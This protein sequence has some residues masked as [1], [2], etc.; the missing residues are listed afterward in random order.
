MAN[1]YINE[2]YKI[3]FKNVVSE[4]YIGK[5]IIGVIENKLKEEF[6]KEN[7]TKIHSLKILTPYL[8]IETI[9]K[10]KYLDE[11]S[12][13]QI[14]TNKGNEK[15]Q[16]LDKIKNN[17]KNI[18]LH[19]FKYNPTTNDFKDKNN[20]L[21]LHAK[22]Y[23]VNEKYLFISSANFT[24]NGTT[25]NFET[26]IFIKPHNYYNYKKKDEDGNPDYEYNNNKLIKN[27]SRKFDEITKDENIIK[28]KETLFSL[29]LNFFKKSN[30]SD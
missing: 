29:I 14:I 8:K 11:N 9:D 10:F 15:R 3:N 19:E 6:E 30:F 25:N 17:T 5:G 1:K 24:S 2:N 28:E 21:N 12:T 7:I 23:L 13:I 16:S 22:I 4:I 26:V 18:V 27:I 20:F